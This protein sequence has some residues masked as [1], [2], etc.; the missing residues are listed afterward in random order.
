MDARQ[1]AFS[2][3]NVNSS[4]EGA[5]LHPFQPRKVIRHVQTDID[6]Q[7]QP[8][9]CTTPPL[10]NYFDVALMT[11]PIDILDVQTANSE[12][13]QLIRNKTSLSTPAKNYIHRLTAR[14]RKH[15]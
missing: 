8:A 12:L 15:L 4:W 3:Q 11:S 14:V 10:T 5:G 9:E 2:I 7:N 6:Q 1:N 13:N